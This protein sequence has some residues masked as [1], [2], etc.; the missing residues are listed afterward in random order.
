L[1]RLKHVAAHLQGLEGNAPRGA[2]GEIVQCLAQP[3]DLAEYKQLRET[4]IDVLIGKG[5]LKADAGNDLHFVREELY[6]HLDRTLGAT[7]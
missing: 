1:L 5:L 4:E 3:S 2:H 6:V 7:P